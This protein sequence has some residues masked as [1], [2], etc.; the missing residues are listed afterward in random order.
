[1]VRNRLWPAMATTI[2]GKHMAH[3]VLV[4]CSDQHCRE[5]TGCYGHPLVRTPNIDALAARGTAFDVAYSAGPICVSARAGIQTGR[6]VHQLGTWSSAEPY[7]GSVPGWGH[8]LQAENRASVSIGKLHFRSTRDNNGFSEEIIPVHVLNGIGFTSSL[9]RDGLETYPSNSDFANDIGRGESRYTKYDRKVCEL[10][11]SWLTDVA[12]EL[13]QAWT[14]FCS[15]VAP[16]HPI[17]APDEFYD[18][19]DRDQ[20]DMP[21]LHAAGERPDHP[22]LDVC[23]VIWDY[24]RHFRDADH[25]REARLSYFG[26]VS[27]M[28]HNVGRVLAALEDSGQA[29]NTLVIYVS[30]HGEMLGNHGLWAKMN[31]YEESSAIPLIAAGPGMPSGV[32]CTAPASH[33]DL[34]PTILKAH[35]LDDETGLDG[36]ALQDL[37]SGGHEDRAVL[38]EYHER[39]AITGMFMTRWRNWKYIAYP[40]YPPQL[41]DMAAD[42]IESSDL[43]RDPAHAANRALC[44]DKLREIVDYEAANRRCFA[45]QTRRIA[46]L[47]GREAAFADGGNAY[48][49]MPEVV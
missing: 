27:F 29:D 42:P 33:I 12:P 36:V 24:D 20:I 2:G 25:I 10:S 49:P 45:D 35:G 11:C 17:V 6:W 48:T 39:G 18:L 43:G 3:N 38:S 30:D 5:A 32:R 9:V 46:A 8:R 19:Y 34:Q 28:D 1:M 4:I 14:L 16:H 23:Q 44:D 26:Y 21:R 31:M 40:G 41:F 15:F 7:D 13:D 47:G 37:V 22:V